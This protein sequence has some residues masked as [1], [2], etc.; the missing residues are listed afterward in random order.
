M[1]SDRDPATLWTSTQAYILAIICLLLGG[2]IGYLLRGSDTAASAARPSAAPA[3]SSAAPAPAQPTPE[4]MRQMADTQAQPLLTQLKQ[5]PDDPEILAQVGNVYY[6]AQVFDQAIGYYKKSL[7]VKEN[8]NVRTDM[9]TA[10][11]YLGD[12]DSAIAEF[13]RV[14]KANPKHDNAMFNLGMVRFQGKMDFAG[15]AEAWE[16]YLKQYPNSPRRADVE[17]LLAR[18]REHAGLK[19]GAITTKPIK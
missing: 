9:G 5:K 11:F 18:A 6:D 16:Q 12:S 14:L 1:S 15:A 4:Q 19:P 13:Q 7:A 3:V 17:Q 2:T 10:E 8:P